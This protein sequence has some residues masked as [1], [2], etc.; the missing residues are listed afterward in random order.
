MDVYCHMYFPEYIAILV[1]IMLSE[2]LHSKRGLGVRT[3]FK[4]ECVAE[5]QEERL[6][7]VAWKRSGS[8]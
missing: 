4:S 3:A 1:I 5:D 8:L 6:C 2:R 7:I